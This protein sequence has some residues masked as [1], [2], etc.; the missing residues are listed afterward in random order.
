MTRLVWLI[1]ALVACGHHE[2]AVGG[3][4][5]PVVDSGVDGARLDASID[6][7]ADAF[8]PLGD[9]I[10]GLSSLPR[11]CTADHWCWWRPQP[12]GNTYDHIATTGLDNIWLTGGT[13]VVYQWDGHT[14]RVHRIPLL[15]DENTTQLTVSIATSGRDNTWVIYGTSLVRWDGTSWSILESG[16]AT[17]NVTL[18]NLWIAPSGDTWVT[19]SNG[20]LHHWHGGTYTVVD[21]GCGCFLGA[22]WGTADDDFFL[23]TIGSIFHSNGSTFTRLS[24]GGKTAAWYSGTPNDVWIS[25]GDAALFHWD[26]SA[27]TAF[28]AGVAAASTIESVGYVAPNDVWWFSSPGSSL[29]YT[30]VHWDGTSITTT[31]LDRSADPYCCS[32]INSAAII[33]GTWW[34][35]G[36]DG[37]IF[38]R[39]AQNALVPIVQPQLWGTQ[40]MWGSSDTDMYFATGG[41]I[42]HWDGASLT[43]IPVAVTGIS[44]VRRSDGTDELFG[45]GLAIDFSTNEYL[46]NAF[47]F[48][49]TTWTKTTLTRSPIGPGSKLLGS[50]LALGPGDAMAIGQAGGM[51]HLTNG[52]WSPVSTGT[53]N[54]LSSVWGPSADTLWITGAAGTLLRWDR[55]NP[56]V[57]KPDATFPATTADLGAVNG[58]DGL[59][60]VSQTQDSHV[61]MFDGAT[62][63]T[64]DTHITPFQIWATSKTDVVVSC[65]GQSR[66]ARWNGTAFNTEDIGA[67]VA[68]SHLFRPPGGQMYLASGS[69]IVVHQ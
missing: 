28:D 5:S 65:S 55:T 57:A 1:G 47:Y 4:A 12:A 20:S 43:T 2:P 64:V 16:P 35:V 31:A 54:D 27:L 14:W 59:V 49:G 18:D 32:T 33:G 25:G 10:G 34:L 58:A 9:P 7:P 6:A 44:G 62:W 50:V 19:L 56:D 36:G 13:N 63:S 48:D 46:A 68:M 8:V 15:P 38:T 41:S 42:L 24:T 23:T 66:L 52:T 40:S 11:V 29:S 21:T 45:V 53:S 69:G 51:Y 61:W 22:I 17:G 37:A 26:G 3:D 60:W 30:A 67:W 39:D